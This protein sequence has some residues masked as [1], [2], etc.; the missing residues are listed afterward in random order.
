MKCL[1]HLDLFSGIGG[2]ALAAKWAG[3]QTIGFVEI[4]GYCQK[5]L[6]KHWSDVPI[7]EDIRDVEKIKEVVAY[8]DKGGY[9][10]DT[11]EA[12][13]KGEDTPKPNPQFSSRGRTGDALCG[14]G[15]RVYAKPPVTL[16]TGG[17]PCQPF[18]VAGKRGGKA[19]DR[20]LWP[21]M[22]RIIEEV[23]PR[24][25]VGEN[26]AGI[27]RMELDTVL[28]DL[29]RIGYTTQAIV[30]PACAVNAPHR[31]DRVWIIAHSESVFSNGSNNNTRIS[32]GRKPLSELGNGSG[33]AIIPDTPNSR[34][35]QRVRDNRI[36][37][38][39]DE[40]RAGQPQ[41]EP[42]ESGQAAAYAH[43]GGLEGAETEGRDSEY[44][45][46]DSKDVRDSEGTGLTPCFVGQG[47][48]QPRRTSS[49][50]G[51][52][53][54]VEPELGRVAHGIPNRVDRLKCLGNAIVPQVAA[55]I[56]KVIKEV[57][58]RTPIR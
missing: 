36:G 48:E 25:V 51:E 34:D 58:D 53:W 9:S 46:G 30:I 17:F 42:C 44:V 41:P 21:A 50:T 52:W 45:V 47:Q 10:P 57:D 13:S 55:E 31:R 18:S 4:D 39:T 33:Q 56:I 3:F 22:F 6:K 2:F 15:F 29:E 35:R 1:T 16:I 40:G 27:V 37:E 8:A 11:R 23:R 20:Y 26:V 54:A 38:T 43:I 12:L 7:V 24:W 5:V 32:V 49:R 14:E 19:D 28:S